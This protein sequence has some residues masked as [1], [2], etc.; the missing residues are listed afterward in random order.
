MRYFTLLLIGVL[1]A[2]VSFGAM[3]DAEAAVVIDRFLADP[4]S[5]SERQSAAKILQFA[6]ESPTHEVT[7]DVKY[8]PWLKETPPPEGSELLLAA[9][10][11]G[12]LKEQI[13]KNTTKSED[14]AGALAV[15]EVYRKLQEKKIVIPE[16]DH[17]I[18]LE[19]QGTL[20]SFIEKD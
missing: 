12:N 9:F 6:E 20:R 13:K 8:M 2:Q 10:M 15:L 19:K 14:Y 7:V 1:S 16:L 3:T 5:P 4:L 17:W 11:A 18:E